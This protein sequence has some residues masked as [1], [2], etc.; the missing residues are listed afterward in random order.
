MRGA[1]P[2]VLQTMRMSEN[3]ELDDVAFEEQGDRPVDDHAELPGDERELVEVVRPRHEPPGETAEPYAEDVG[4]ALVP[5]E[6]RDLPEHPV[7]V[8]LGVPGE[9]LRETPRLARRVLARRRVGTVGLRVRNAG[10]VAE[11]PHVLVAANAQE[12][13]DL[14]AA[15]V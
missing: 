7:A 5:A 8:R 13:V 11:R 14:D 12:L 9:G 15:P 2:V 4:D 10:A 3:R 1:L 6:G